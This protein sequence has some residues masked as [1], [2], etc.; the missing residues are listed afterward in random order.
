[1][2]RPTVDMKPRALFAIILGIVALIASGCGGSDSTP[3][4]V[5]VAGSGSELA[6]SSTVPIIAPYEGV[7]EALIDEL[8]ELA[9]EEAKS[10]AKLRTY[11]FGANDLNVTFMN[12]FPGITEE[13]VVT[14]LT[15]SSRIVQESEAN[16]RTA[17]YAATS[18]AQAA[19]LM[20]RGLLEQIDWARWGV[21]KSL[22]EPELNSFVADVGNTANIFNTEKLNKSDL[23]SSLFDF[24]DSKWEG[25]LTATPGLLPAAMGSWAMQFGTDSAIELLDDLIGS[26]TLLVTNNASQLVLS[27]ERPVLMAGSPA[28]GA[29]VGWLQGAPIDISFYEGSQLIPLHAIVIRDSEARH[30]AILKAV[31]STTIDGRRLA[32]QEKAGWT[33]SM[34]PLADPDDRMVKEIKE[35][36]SFFSRETLENWQERNEKTGAIRQFV[37]NQ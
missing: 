2:H 4:A 12:R 36:V 8:Y 28:F 5:Q 20:E 34:G 14:G 11:L 1:M 32:I 7:P 18:I 9:L 19:P 26:G 27:G 33:A 22:I 29:N 37:L 35:N 3:T 10:G 21:P 23:P 15:R 16:Q 17:D 24:K 13:V 25:K 31:W 6:A 30:T